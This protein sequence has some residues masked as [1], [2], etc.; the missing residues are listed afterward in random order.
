MGPEDVIEVLV[1]REDDLSK[2]VTIRPDGKVSLPLIGDI[3]AAG[4]T[5]E[6]LKETITKR[7]KEFIDNPTVSVIVA[8]INSMR[9]FIQGEVMTPGVY[10]L[11]NYTTVLQAISL[12]GGFN[13]WAKR[14]EIIIIRD[15]EGVRWRIPVDYE[16]IIS[17]KDIDQNI[18]LERGDTII[19]P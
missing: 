17:G 9:I 15:V 2:E 3:Q 1:W 13:E 7:L 11:R 19:V 12:A 5:T 10:Q 18:I 8:Q 16:K 4:L 14:K 6:N